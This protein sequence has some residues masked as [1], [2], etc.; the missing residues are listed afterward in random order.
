MLV[1]HTSYRCT[2]R[3]RDSRE[4][5]FSWFPT[6]R[7]REDAGR[8]LKSNLV[9]WNVI[10]LDHIMCIVVLA[11]TPPADLNVQFAAA[12]LATNPVPSKKRKNCRGF[13][14]I[15]ITYD[16]YVCSVSQAARELDLCAA[17]SAL[18]PCCAAHSPLVTTEVE[19]L[20]RH[21]GR[22]G[23]LTLNHCHRQ[24]A[25]PNG[26]QYFGRLGRIISLLNEQSGMFRA[27]MGVTV[28]SGIAL[29]FRKWTVRERLHPPH[30]FAP[31]IQDDLL[32]GLNTC[33][34]AF[35]GVEFIWT[36]DICRRD[37]DEF[38]GR[39]CN[40]LSGAATT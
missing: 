7:V 40:A 5:H 16:E 4:H 36:A 35:D 2:A 29:N 37:L 34:K 15:N 17:P 25:S 32:V 9:G 19:R 26:W 33:G 30:F 23:A 21:Q 38:D 18:I 27:Q 28:P 12:L 20:G 39:P 1:N 31:G 24:H 8:R 13:Q 3:S 14:M 10:R 6:K 22:C 11:I